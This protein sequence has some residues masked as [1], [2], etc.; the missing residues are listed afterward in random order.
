MPVRQA[1]AQWEGDLKQG[2]GSM[3]LGSGAWEGPYSFGSRFE[4]AQ[5]SNP[6]EMLGAAH[7]GCFT[8]ALANKLA[9]AGHPAQRVHTTAQVH[10]DK[11]GEGF[12]ITRIQL[13]TEGSVPGISEQEFKRLAEDAKANCLV[14]KVLKGLSIELQATL[15]R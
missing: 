2:R 1:K 6:E 13:T 11:S 12:G 10:L 3:K 9:Q 4:G 7:A 14:S 8:M 5:G 15:A